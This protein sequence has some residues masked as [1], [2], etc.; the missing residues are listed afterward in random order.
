MRSLRAS[1]WFC[2]ALA[3]GLTAG[4]VACGSSGAGGNTGTGP[5]TGVGIGG[6]WSYSATATTGDTVCTITGAVLTLTQAGPNITGTFTQAQLAC[7][8]T[9]ISATASDTVSNG[10]ITGLNVAFDLDTAGIVVHNT[11]TTNNTETL[12][13][14]NVVV[15]FFTDSITGTWSATR[16]GS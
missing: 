4:I 7:T 6:T 8:N 2:V 9:T 3:G 15:R 1:R 10:T 13:S 11:G 16:T 14:G 12:M 5:P